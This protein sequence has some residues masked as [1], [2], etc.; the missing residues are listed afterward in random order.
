MSTALTIMKAGL[1]IDIIGVMKFRFMSI[2][3]IFIIVVLIIIIILVR[4]RQLYART[5]PLYFVHRGVDCSFPT[6]HAAS[7][8]LSHHP[9]TQL[10]KMLFTTARN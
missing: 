9:L 1:T 5:A 2:Y 6:C 8:C 7:G 10:S 4:N 3:I